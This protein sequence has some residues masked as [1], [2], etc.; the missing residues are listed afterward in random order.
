MLS[1]EFFRARLRGDENDGEIKMR[2]G[3]VRIVGDSLKDLLLCFFLSPFLAERTRPC[4]F[5]CR[6]VLDGSGLFG[7]ASLS[8]SD[9][10]SAFAVLV[11]FAVDFFSNTKLALNKPA[12]SY[13]T[14]TTGCRSKASSSLFNFVSGCARNS[15]CLFNVS[16]VT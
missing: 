1:G 8:P 12:R 10:A 11:E 13:E 15:T 3:V 4:T 5:G 2:I 14:E 6:S 7:L 9:L 16:D